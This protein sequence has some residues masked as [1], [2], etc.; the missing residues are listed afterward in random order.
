MAR[1]STETVHDTQ[2]FC[3]TQVLCAR[4]NAHTLLTSEM[5]FWI[6]SA[7]KSGRNRVCNDRIQ[8]LIGERNTILDGIKSK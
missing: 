1:Q 2:I 3:V 8:K 4:Q 7:G 5:D 6:R